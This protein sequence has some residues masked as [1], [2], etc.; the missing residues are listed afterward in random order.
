MATLDTEGER[1][2]AGQTGRVA[3]SALVAECEITDRAGQ[4]DRCRSACA[5]EVGAGQTAA[6]TAGAH[7]EAVP[8]ELAGGVDPRT[9]CACLGAGRTGPAREGE[10]LQ[11]AQA[12]RA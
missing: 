7:V 10:T 4:T 8:A 5:A 1:L 12:L 2:V 3:G 9:V 6:G 11:A